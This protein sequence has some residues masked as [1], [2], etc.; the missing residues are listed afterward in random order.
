MIYAREIHLLGALVPT[1]DQ[2]ELL[3]D[4]TLAGLGVSRSDG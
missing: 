3:A 2:L 1:Y 4:A